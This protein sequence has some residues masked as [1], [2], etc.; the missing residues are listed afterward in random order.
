MK[1]K[2]ESLTIQCACAS[3]SSQAANIH[4]VLSLSSK[5]FDNSGPMNRSRAV[6][7]FSPPVIGFFAY[8]IK[9][10]L[11]SLTTLGPDPI[12]KSGD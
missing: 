10:G 4:N 8:Q 11:K 7:L 1:I 5:S 2:I 9:L 12:P 3:C 6:C